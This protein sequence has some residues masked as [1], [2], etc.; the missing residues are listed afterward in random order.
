MFHDVYYSEGVISLT[1]WV[2]CSLVSR[3]LAQAVLLTMR[4]A[5]SWLLSL[6]L[7]AAGALRLR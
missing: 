4:M 2:T 7:A 3:A 1:R 6:A 5:L